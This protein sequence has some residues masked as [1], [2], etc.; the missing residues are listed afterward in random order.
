M[1]KYNKIMAKYLKQKYKESY[2]IQS[3]EVEKEIKDNVVCK[4]DKDLLI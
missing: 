2:F 1:L 4:L 3:Y